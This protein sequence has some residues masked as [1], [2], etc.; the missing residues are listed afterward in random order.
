MKMFAI[1]A[2]TGGLST[3]SLMPARADTTVQVIRV[4]NQNLQQVSTTLTDCVDLPPGQR[5]NANKST[6]LVTTLQLSTGVTLIQTQ[7]QEWDANYYTAAA[8]YGCEY[9]QQQLAA[10]AEAFLL[11]LHSIREID[12]FREGP[13]EGCYSKV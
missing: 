4:S 5:N 1:L 2:V 12:T 3:L 10:S 11:D 8:G 7:K 13:N 9:F 6:S